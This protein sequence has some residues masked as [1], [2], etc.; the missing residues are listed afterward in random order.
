M[1]LRNHLLLWFTIIG[2][3]P[4]AAVL[5]FANQYYRGVYLAEIDDEMQGELRRLS[6]SID[7]QFQHQRNLLRTLGSASL[8]QRFIDELEQVIELGHVTR[9]YRIAKAQLKAFL[10]NLEPVVGEPAVIRVLD[11][12]GN[13]VVQVTYG[14]LSKPELE[15]LLP[16]PLLEVEVSP[17]FSVQLGSLPDGEIAYLRLPQP[18]PLPQEIRPPI[19][20]AVW[21]LR[22]DGQ[23]AY[24][25]YSSTGRRFDRL[26]ALTPRLRD[27]KIGIIENA[28]EDGGPPKWIFSDQPPLFFSGKRRDDLPLPGAV[29][30]Y[31]A[32]AGSDS[33]I[34]GARYRWL[35]TEYFP[36][37]DRLVSWVLSQRLDNDQIGGQFR[38]I[39]YGLLALTLVM[40]LFSILLASLAA[41]RLAR[42]VTQLARNMRNYAS[43]VPVGDTPR[44][45]SSEVN[46]L[47]SEFKQMIAGLEK[48]REARK[49]AE[50]K[51]VKSARLASIGEMAAGI[52]H[53]LNNP[54]TNILSLAKLIARDTERCPEV[55]EDAEAI[56]AET[57]RA[58]HIVKGILNFARQIEP[59]YEPVNVRDWIET[60]I[61]RAAS[62]LEGKDIALEVEVDEVLTMEADRYQMEQ[63]LL[64]LL[65]NAIYASPQGGEIRITAQEDDG[66][67]RVLVI[68]HGT[69]ID[70]QI[71]ERLFEPFATSKP[72]GDGSGLGLSISL[73]IV[74]MHGGQLRLVN[75]E[76]GGCT[77][78]I[79]IPRVRA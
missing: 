11:P 33:V 37:P 41:R 53:E 77:A 31:I 23:R 70:P 19:L 3:L 18:T 50:R 27:A 63:V 16:Y 74:E 47:E 61:R 36:Y 20:D 29:R 65:Q 46:A 60:S 54:L 14:G 22:L 71:E 24:L 49:R 42:P 7:Q 5:F 12:E 64:N 40:A 62:A 69:G 79:R 78:E 73:G 66:W 35:F 56:I 26:L 44:S 55:A 68:D 67:L 59:V 25:V 6:A 76:A 15:S 43:G 13:T 72:V 51:L 45:W 4:L 52:G 8:M 21:P 38:V 30:R 48:A 9:E 75:N 32:G 2:L 34:S 39:S 17:A 58:A 57:R 1:K 28:A 10:L